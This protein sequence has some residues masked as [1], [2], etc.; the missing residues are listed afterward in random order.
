MQKQQNVYSFQAHREHSPGWIRCYSTKQ[1]LINLRTVNHI[2]P[3]FLT[4]T[5]WNY[6]SIR[7]ENTGKFTNTWRLNNIQLNSQQVKVK[8]TEKQKNIET[9]NGN[10]IY[11]NLWDAAKA[12]PRGKF[13]AINTYAEK[14]KISNKE[15]NFISQAT[16][17]SSSSSRRRE[18]KI[19]AEIN[20]IETRKTT[21]NKSIKLRAG[22]LN[23]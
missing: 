17:K 4:T 18:I 16:I 21:E 2:K 19:I 20:E 22:F 23:R 13:I 5:V 9:N 10:T 14:R 11:S 6:K 15:P 8:S 1:I 12:V 3:S 7:R